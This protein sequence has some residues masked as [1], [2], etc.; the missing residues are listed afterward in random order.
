MNATVIFN[1]KETRVLRNIKYFKM[2]DVSNTLYAYLDNR[3]VHSIWCKRN[4][5]GII[6]NTNFMIYLENEVDDVA[7]E[8][9]LNMFEVIIPAFGEDESIIIAAQGYEHN[10]YT[11]EVVFY[12]NNGGYREDVAAI[13]YANICGIQK[14]ELVKPE[15]QE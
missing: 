15:V 4:I 12:V 11:D 9:K 8:K 1:N 6:N 7:K 5:V 3:K 14:Y 10:T 2:S 13:N